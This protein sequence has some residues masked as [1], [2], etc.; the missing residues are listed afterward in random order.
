VIIACA[1]GMVTMVPTPVA[2]QATASAT[3]SRRAGNQRP[4]SPAL[5]TPDTAAPPK[6]SM[7]PMVA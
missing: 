6:P 3:P 7:T 2:D 5:S 4:S 1:A